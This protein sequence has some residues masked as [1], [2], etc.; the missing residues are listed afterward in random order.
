[1]HKL[2]SEDLDFF[3]AD[4]ATQS[5]FNPKEEFSTKKNCQLISLYKEEVGLIFLYLL[6]DDIE[7]Y[8]DEWRYLIGFS[9]GDE[10]V[11]GG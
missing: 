6:F 8:K 5:L 9:Q 11:P 4:W 3:G 1:M 7:K 10:V 2:G